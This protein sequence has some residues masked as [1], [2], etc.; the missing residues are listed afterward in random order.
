MNDDLVRVKLSEGS[1]NAP[2]QYRKL[3]DAINATPDRHTPEGWPD[4]NGPGW[5]DVGYTTPAE[6][7]PIVHGRLGRD[8]TIRVNEAE[9]EPGRYRVAFQGEIVGEVNVT[10]PVTHVVKN[11][12]DRRKERYRNGNTNPH[13]DQTGRRW[14]V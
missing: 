4:P 13:R 6:K 2:E 12:A 10:D 9:L 11:R 14:A 1:H 7:L 5:T 8:G 3:A